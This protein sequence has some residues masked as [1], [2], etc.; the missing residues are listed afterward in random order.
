MGARRDTN[1]CSQKSDRGGPPGEQSVSVAGFAEHV[2]GGG[3]TTT[4]WKIRITAR[5]RLRRFAGVST[6]VAAGTNCPAAGRL[7]STHAIGAMTI[8]RSGAVSIVAKRTRR[9]RASP[10]DLRQ[11]R[12]GATTWRLPTIP[13]MDRATPPVPSAD[14]AC[15][16]SEPAR[17]PCISLSRSEPRSAR[18]REGIAPRAGHGEWEP[19]PDRRDPVELLE[20]QAAS[21][22]PELVPIRYGRMLVSPFTFFRG[23]AY[24]MAADLAA[25]PR[26]G[27]RRA[28]VRRCAP[29]ELRRFRA[30]PIGGWCSAST[31]STRRCRARSSGT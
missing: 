9:T 7:R 11:R 4:I 18:P 14:Q 21:R 2:P 1:W 10:S 22:V 26:T 31:T 13:A 5:G 29:V 28:A 3:L 15:V 20:E 25:A 23:A 17:A 24:P 12:K 27:L 19:A 6:A 16:G 30:R 8:R